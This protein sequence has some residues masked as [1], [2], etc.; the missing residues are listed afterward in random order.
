MNPLVME[1]GCHFTSNSVVVGTTEVMTGGPGT[2]S[3]GLVSTTRLSLDLPIPRDVT[4][5]TRN[6][7][8][9]LGERLAMFVSSRRDLEVFTTLSLFNSTLYFRKY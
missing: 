3:S 1:G 4:A 6:L 7:Y 2:W 5:A 9:V 8:V